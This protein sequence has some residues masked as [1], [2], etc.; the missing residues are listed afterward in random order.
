MA[1]GHKAP[2]RAIG[3]TAKGKVENI[4]EILNRKGFVSG[5]ITTDEISGATPSSFYAHQM[6][7]SLSDGIRKDLE[8][9]YIAV[10]AS[11]DRSE[12]FKDSK[13]TFLKSP[14]DLALQLILT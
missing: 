9:S 11:T 14:E 3:M 12:S 13:F 1:T 8:K 4:T 5:I 10:I 6:D 7:R 2:N